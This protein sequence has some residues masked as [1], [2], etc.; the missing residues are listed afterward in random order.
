MIVNRSIGDN[1]VLYESY[2]FRHSS[3]L[4]YDYGN[5]QLCLCLRRVALVQTPYWKRIASK[6]LI[7]NLKSRDEIFS[8]LFFN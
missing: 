8:L 4:F 7:G 1:Q 2:M 5:F 6:G 3:S